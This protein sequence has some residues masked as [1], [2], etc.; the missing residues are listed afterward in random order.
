MQIEIDK[1]NDVIRLYEQYTGVAESTFSVMKQNLELRNTIQGD[2]LKAA[3][4]LPIYKAKCKRRGLTIAIGIPVSLAIG[5]GV[6]YAF[7]LF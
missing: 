5:F 1:Q 2:C 3:Q 4:E 6:G 7:G